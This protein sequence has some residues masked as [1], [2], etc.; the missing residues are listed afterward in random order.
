MPGWTAPGPGDPIHWTSSTL[1]ILK[2]CPRLQIFPLNLRLLTWVDNGQLKSNLFQTKLLIFL[3]NPVLPSLP[4]SV[5]GNSILSAAQA[6]CII[7]NPCLSLTLQSHP[8]GDLTLPSK[9]IHVQQHLTTATWSNPLISP[10]FLPASYVAGP[11][12]FALARLYKKQ[13]MLINGKWDHANYL[14]K[15]CL[16]LPTSLRSKS[17]PWLIIPTICSL[18]SVQFLEISDSRTTSKVSNVCGYFQKQKRSSILLPSFLN[19]LVRFSKKLM[20]QKW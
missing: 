2:L 14:L 5:N 1:R 12:S 19:T 18:F 9:N 11:P 13:V 3:P 6:K 15:I 4:I 7:F 8:S 10:E 20:N 16:C 17:R